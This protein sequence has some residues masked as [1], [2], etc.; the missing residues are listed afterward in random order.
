MSIGAIIVLAVLLAFFVLVVANINSPVID[1][2]DKYVAVVV[3]LAIDVIL[4]SVV[5]YY[6]LFGN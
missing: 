6:G 2:K 4:M 3:L 1:D 5:V